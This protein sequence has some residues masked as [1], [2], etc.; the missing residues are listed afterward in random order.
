MI[1]S[2][3]GIVLE[4]TPL[5]VVLEVA[6][7]GYEVQ[8]PVTTAERL[9]APGGEARLFIH[10]VY[11]EDS[12][13]LF[14]FASRDDRELFRLLIEKVTGVGPKVAL[15]VLSSLSRPV[16][17]AAIRNHD[18]ALLAKCPGIGR[19]TAERI[20]IELRDA[21]G[22]LPGTAPV[23]GG[24]PLPGAAD[25]PGAEPTAIADAVQALLSLGYK[26]AEAD[27]AIRL[28]ARNLGETASTET[29]L[30]HALSG[31]K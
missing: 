10:A 21:I 16:L 26:P 29:L 11:R 15:A 17:E 22:K 4:S 31:G 14:G 27:K 5:Q 28:A 7:V 12:Q 30:R 24:S 20:V 23:T 2:L 6:G 3:R 9:P 18:I 19:K 8:V 1:A 13:H 25:A